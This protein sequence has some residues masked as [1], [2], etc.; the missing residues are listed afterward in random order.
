MTA[1]RRSSLLFM[2]LGDHHIKN[3]LIN[4]GIYNLDKTIEEKS[5]FD[6]RKRI[7]NARVNIN[8]LDSF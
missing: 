4:T 5:V 7:E 1:G 3:L 6:S 2:Y 8:F